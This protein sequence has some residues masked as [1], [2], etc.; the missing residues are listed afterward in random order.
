MGKSLDPGPL[1]RRAAAADAQAVFDLQEELFAGDVNRL[2]RE[3]LSAPGE[4]KQAIVLVAELAGAV[5]GFLVLRSRTARPWTGIDFVGVAPHAAGRGIGGK[6]LEAACR[7]SPRPIL[8]LF[9]RPSNTAAR[10]L[11][12]RLGFRHTATRKAS[13]A[14]GEDALVHMKWVGLRMFRHNPEMLQ[15]PEPQ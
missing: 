4:D 12:A 1:I 7:V 5:A 3:V 14:D 13:Y 11:Y 8:R 2:S 10:A 15:R 9:V 6:L